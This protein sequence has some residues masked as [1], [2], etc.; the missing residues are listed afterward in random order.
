MTFLSEVFHLGA[1]LGMPFSFS[2]SRNSPDFANGFP[3]RPLRL[4]GQCGGEAVAGE[5]KTHGI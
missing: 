1:L 2:Q 4:A 3:L 5:Q